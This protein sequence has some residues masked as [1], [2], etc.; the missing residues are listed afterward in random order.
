MAAFDDLELADLL[1]RP[2][3]L[4]TYDAVALGAQATDLPFARMAGAG[5]PPRRIVLPTTVVTRGGLREPGMS[6]M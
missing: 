3:T 4:V 1:R 6:P 2:V 5:D